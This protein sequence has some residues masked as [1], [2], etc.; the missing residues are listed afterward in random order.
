MRADDLAQDVVDLRQFRIKAICPRT[1][2]L[3]SG[4]GDRQKGHPRRAE[5]FALPKRGTMWP[6]RPFAPFALSPIR[7][8]PFLHDRHSLANLTPARKIPRVW[9]SGALIRFHW[10]D[11]AILTFQENTTPISLLLQRQSVSLRPQT[12]KALHKFVFRALQKS[13]DGR[14]L[15]VGNAH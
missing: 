6:L 5:I 14:D 13:G 12:G 15:A 8:P 2:R 4:A 7:L 1:V 3:K 11:P 10:L 9:E